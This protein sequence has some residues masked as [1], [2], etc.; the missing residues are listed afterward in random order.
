MSEAMMW[1]MGR[2]IWETVV[3]TFVS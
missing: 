3:M 2:G 1:L